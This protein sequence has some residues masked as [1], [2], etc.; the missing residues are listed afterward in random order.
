M[1]FVSGYLSQPERMAGLISPAVVSPL[2]MG[3]YQ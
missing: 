2:V 1:V 3:H